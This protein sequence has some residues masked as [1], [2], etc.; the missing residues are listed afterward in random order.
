MGVA[1][2]EQ[3]IERLR[4][5]K[6]VAYRAGQRMEN[7]V[8]DYE[9][10][11]G[12][13]CLGT[14]F[15]SA[16][17]P[18]YSDLATLKS[19]LI[20]E[21]IN[22][23]TNLVTSPE[24]AVAKAQLMMTVA[25]DYSCPCVYRCIT[26]DRV[27]LAWV[28]SYEIDKKYGTHYH[29]NVKRIV[30]EIQEK[31]LVI[32]GGTVDPRGDRSLRPVQQP[33]MFVR[34]VDKG[35]DGIVV[36]GAKA[37]STA[38]IYAD[39]LSVI[40]GKPMKEDEK[41][42]AVGFFTPLDAEGVK[43]IVRGIPEVSKTEPLANMIGRQYGHSE[44]FVIYDNVF[45][46]WE[47]VFMCGEYDA[48]YLIAA[49]GSGHHMLSKCSCRTAAMQL[50]I[51]ATALIAEMNGTSKAPHINSYIVEMIMNRE[52]VKACA[53]AAATTG[54]M[55][56]SGAYI[57]NGVPAQTGK[58]FAA[59][60]LGEHRYYMQDAAG[61]LTQTMSHEKDL[62]N[63]ETREYLEKYLQGKAGIPVED[64]F[65]AFKLVEELTSSPF[66][67]WYHAMCITGGGGPEILR[68]AVKWETDISKFVERAKAVA[69]IS[70]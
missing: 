42:F 23:W 55:H 60:K 13:N 29:E 37:H 24:D 4:K 62:L 28:V 52:I 31:D 1:T 47:N 27:N 16:N 32:G 2:K 54:H 67:G 9:I 63:P 64:R 5:Q 38:A 12:I 66:A 11:L 53:I 30:K 58:V 59:R 6:P 41:D 49:I 44:V 10:Q 14:T 19:P 33:E 3:Y 43:M 57:P 45:V 56:E 48:T 26:S 35:K 15:E 25:G 22:R 65:R 50:D 46:P 34:V 61:G 40:P 69:G 7:I 51:G 39:L 18:K 8:D 70:T 21:K 36:R 20:N 68:Q 17:D